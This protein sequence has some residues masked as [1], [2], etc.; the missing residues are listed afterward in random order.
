[1][2]RWLALLA[3]VLTGYPVAAR[4]Q[5][6]LPVRVAG[7]TSA[8]AAA[9]IEIALRFHGPVAK[10][11]EVIRLV[12]SPG[13]RDWRLADRSRVANADGASAVGGGVGLE[14]LLI[15]RAAGQ[16]GYLVAGP[17]YWP[18][19]STTIGVPAVW[20]RTVRG[21]WSRSDTGLPVWLG[22]PASSSKWPLCVS[23]PGGEWQCL[24]VPLQERGVV[25]SSAGAETLF[26]IARG[27]A[28]ASGVEFVNPSSAAW[29]RLVVVGR[30]DRVSVTPA[31]AVVLSAR[32]LQV[33]R[34]RRLPSRAHTEADPRVSVDVLAPGVFWVS[35][36]ESPK[37][38]WIEIKGSGHAPMR[39]QVADLAAMSAEL[40]VHVDLEAA[41]A[42][43]G[44][45]SDEGGDAAAGAIVTLYRLIPD[46]RTDQKRPPGRVM[47]DEVT[48]GEDGAFHFAGVAREPHTVLAFHATKGRVERAIDPDDRDVQLQLRSPSRA[49]GRVLRGGVPAAGVRVSTAPDLMEFA[50]ADD[51]TELFGGQ[52]ATDRDGRF[53]LSLPPRGTVE[54]RVGGDGTGVRRVTLGAAGALPRVVDVGTIDLSPLPRLTLVLEESSGCE[55]LLI[56]PIGRTGL[57]IYA[58]TRLGASMFEARL[59]EPGTWSITAR[60]AGQS[61][62]LVPLSVTMDDGA[63]E[64]T[65]Q[66]AWR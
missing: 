44:R 60:C 27:T 25:V 45:V 12:R 13:E 38:S 64:Q 11:L 29:G 19:R 41:S 61:R 53:T 66:L 31:D 34:T 46:P 24:G 52:T 62:A 16:P 43:S 4:G 42:V 65:V 48:S 33:P 39:L 63:G 17:L 21:R 10:E 23:L 5:S 26:G 51:V 2:S 3:L 30:A 14:T 15:M 32:K 37:E 18:A 54:L 56:G 57:T 59:P 55:L 50:A 36:R 20:R 47:V 58:A 1:M 28:S 49:T 8:S 6:D 40:P 35:G 7:T 9:T 22:A